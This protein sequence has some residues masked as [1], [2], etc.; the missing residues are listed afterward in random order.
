MVNSGHC[1]TS[2]TWSSTAKA[3]SHVRVSLS[4]RTGLIVQQRDAD[5]DLEQV[6]REAFCEEGVT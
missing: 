4:E 2:H 5:M 1:S 3:M 6:V